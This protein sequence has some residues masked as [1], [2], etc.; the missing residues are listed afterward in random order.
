MDTIERVCQPTLEPGGQDSIS[1]SDTA[2]QHCT[3]SPSVEVTTV[4]PNSAT[5]ADRLPPV[6]NIRPSSDAQ[7][8]P[9]GDAPT[10]SCMAYLR[11][12]YR[13]QH[14]SKEAA[15]PMLK[16]WRTKTTDPIIHCSP[17]GN[18]GVLNGV[19]IPFLALYLK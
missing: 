10:T 17:S 3:G 15:D 8:G 7:S 16:L 5:D 18:A 12:R 9:I 6:N 11:E 13:G 14:L 2:G 19:Q 1:G 4:V